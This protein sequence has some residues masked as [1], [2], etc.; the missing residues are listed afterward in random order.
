MSQPKVDHRGYQQG[1]A[2]ER[3]PNA[4]SQNLLLF[5]IPHADDE[6]EYRVDAGF[7]DTKEE[8]ICQDSRVRLAR[9]GGKH[10]D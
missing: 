7:N 9:G 4:G 8:S 6:H 3:K 2:A 5:R 10:D 1:A